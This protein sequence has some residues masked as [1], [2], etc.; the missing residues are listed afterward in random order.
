[1][2]NYVITISRR[3][4]SKGHE[5]AGL[6]GRILGIPVYDRSAVEARTMMSLQPDVQT[7]SKS[8]KADAGSRDR[9]RNENGGK[10]LIMGLLRREVRDE[11]RD[12]AQLE[13]ERQSEVIRSLAAEG[14]CIVLGRCADQIF[15]DHPRALHV[16]IF[17]S[18]EVRIRNTMDMLHTDEDAARTLM[19][20]ED[21]A[22]EAYRRRFST[23]PDDEVAGHHILIDSGKLGAA[24]T[25]DILAQAAKYLFL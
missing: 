9:H 21:R 14:P 2:D 5:I 25:A 1:M 16:F 17:A 3:F 24:K 18:E 11:I 8:E 15:Q 7:V 12:E 6:T 10:S 19:K 23:H 13:F 4:A 22:R 20:N